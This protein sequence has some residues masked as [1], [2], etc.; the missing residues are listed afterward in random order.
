MFTYISIEEFADGVVKN[1]KDANRKELIASLR[2]SLAAKKNGARCMICGAPIWAAGSGVVK[3]YDNGNIGPDD[4]VTREQMAAIL[5][6]YAVYGGMTA[7]TL[8][9]NLG[10]F[11]D[12]AQLSAY[13]IQAMNWAVGQ[14]L[15]NGSGSNLV[16]KAQAT[17]AQVAAIIHRYLER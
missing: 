12:T 4:A 3:G 2:E 8:E 6:R 1:N 7:V 17:R 13:A 5:Y 11:A 10:S 14:G 15:I 9:E 16:P